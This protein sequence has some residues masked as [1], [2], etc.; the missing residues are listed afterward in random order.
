MHRLRPTEEVLSR[1]ER[2]VEQLALRTRESISRTGLPLETMLVG[3]VAKGTYIGIP[4]IDLF[5]LFPP[6]TERTDLQRLGLRIGEEVIGGEK[7]YAEHP[8]THGNFQGF[9]VDLVPCYKIEDTDQL[10]S[11][12]DRTPFHTRYVLGRLSGEQRDHVRLLKQ[13]MKGVGVYGAEARVQGFSGYLT[14]L[15]VI[16][17]GDFARVVKEAAKWRPGLT[18]DVE[19]IKKAGGTA[20]LTFADPVD[21]KRNVASAL[22][23]DCLSL[24][25]HACQEYA[26]GPDER[27]FFPRDRPP[28][29]LESIKA[30]FYPRG[31]CPL[32]VVLGRPDLVDDNLYPQVQRTLLGLEKL[33]QNQDFKVLDRSYTVGK[34][35]R[36]AFELESGLLPPG[37]LH[38][39]PPV[40][41]GNAQ[42]FLEKWRENGLGQPFLSAG[43]WMVHV[44]RE[45]R[46]PGALIGQ[47]GQEA[48]LGNGFRTLD[49]IRCYVGTK[50]FQ[51]GNRPVLTKLLDKREN[52]RI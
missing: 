5:V 50:A 17:Y 20:P 47:K 31:T 12:V 15:L 32:V 42:E 11:A 22:S 36:L 43:R 29:D 18:M 34:D 52:W 41:T 30:A 1:L 21:L 4:D 49:G 19:M 7:R 2:A 6:S 33:L 25:I 40:W 3:S 28:W 46:D 26:R 9:E 8:Y 24:F 37:R 48:A 23:L 39:G 45:F 14:E 10:R 38:Q 13:F 35:V 51:A 16:R 44:K 27:F